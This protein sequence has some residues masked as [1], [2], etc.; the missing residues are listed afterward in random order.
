MR[1]DFRLSKGTPFMHELMALLS[2]YV[3][4]RLNSDSKWERLKVDMRFCSQ[5]LPYQV[6]DLGCFVGI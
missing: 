5:E 3:D 6:K 2:E 4:A 1:T